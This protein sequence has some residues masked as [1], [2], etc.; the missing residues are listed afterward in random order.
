MMISSARDV[1]VVRYPC[2][3][4]VGYICHLGSYSLLCNF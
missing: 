4:Q 2:D 3:V 1:V